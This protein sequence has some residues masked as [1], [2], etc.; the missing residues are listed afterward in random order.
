MR[1][2][3]GNCSLVDIEKARRKVS[4]PSNVA[5]STMVRSFQNPVYALHRTLPT[6][7]HGLA[8]SGG[9]GLAASHSGQRAFPQCDKLDHKSKNTAARDSPSMTV[10]IHNPNDQS[11]D[12]RYQRSN[13]LTGCPS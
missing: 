6:G 8:G 11:P 10:A 2:W 3:L 4:R 9:W 1:G 7:S 12:A 13:R 5:L